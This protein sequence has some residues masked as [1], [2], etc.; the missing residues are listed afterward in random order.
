MRSKPTDLRHFDPSQHIGPLP[1][2]CIGVCVM[3]QVSGLCTG[4]E[5]TLA[6]IKDWSA[7]SETTKFQVWTAIR[8]RRRLV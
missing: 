2:P 4:C 5:R 8:T 1:S 6:E 7:A 3:D